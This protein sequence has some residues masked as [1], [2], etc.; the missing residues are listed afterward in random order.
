MPSRPQSPP[1]GGVDYLAATS[2]SSGYDYFPL[3]ALCEPHGCA[4]MVRAAR[5]LCRGA[6]NNVALFLPRSAAL[7][8]IAALAQPAGDE[9]TRRLVDVEEAWMGHK[10]KALVAYM[11]DLAQW[12]EEWQAG[13]G[14][15]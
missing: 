14:W 3:G 11:G 4:G 10:L 15:E 9:A 7:A 6:G 1:W 8:D 12:E 13:W 2:A 5:R